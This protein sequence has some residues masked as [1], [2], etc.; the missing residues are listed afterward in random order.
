[1]GGIATGAPSKPPNFPG[2][3]IE[4]MYPPQV[5]ERMLVGEAGVRYTDLILP[6]LFFHWTVLLLAG[7]LGLQERDG[8]ATTRGRHLGPHQSEGW[9]L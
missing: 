3:V 6:P 8:E 9:G 7:S 4:S 5:A 2:A 1:M